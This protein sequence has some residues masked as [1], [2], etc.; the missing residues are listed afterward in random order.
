MVGE[1]GE[2]LN[3]SPDTSSDLSSLF[4]TLADWEYQLRHLPPEDLEFLEDSFEEPAP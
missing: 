3:R 1:D 2:E 4:D